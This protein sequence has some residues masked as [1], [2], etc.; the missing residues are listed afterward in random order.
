MNIYLCN[1]FFFS[2]SICVNLCIAFTANDDFT[3]GSAGL[4][5]SK[6][7]IRIQQRNG[8]KC[9]TTIQGLEDDLDLKR[10]CKAMKR[11]FNC[12]GNVAENPVEQGGGEVIQLQGDQ[13]ENVKDWLLAQ[14]IVLK[15]DADR[16]VLHGF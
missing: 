13:R 14:E 16:L 1:I 6:I 8:R 3:S 4:T 15:G 5:K 2:I 11:N 9:I 10:I 12:N 7:H